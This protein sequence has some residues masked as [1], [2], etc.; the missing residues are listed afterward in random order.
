MLL[1][2]QVRPPI[3]MSI[4]RRGFILVSFV[5]VWRTGAKSLFSAWCRISWNSIPDHH[6]SAHHVLSR[7]HEIIV[8]FL[9]LS[10]GWTDLL[11]LL[12]RSLDDTPHS[13]ELP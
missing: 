6:F 13:I 9:I 3:A 11:P 1:P 10:D 5:A 8:E 7:V 12:A 4:R 2:R